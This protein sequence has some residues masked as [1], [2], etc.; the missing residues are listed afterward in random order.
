MLARA[1]PIEQLRL[2]GDDAPV[3]AIWLSERQSVFCLVDAVD[4]PWICQRPY[5]IGWKER[6]RWKLYAKRNIGTNRT[7]V[8][9]HREIQMLADPRD[10]NFMSWHHVDHINGQCLDNRRCNLRWLTPTENRLHVTPREQIPSLA[11]IVAQILA[12]RAHG[13]APIEAIPF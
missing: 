3:R 9:L 2:L 4:Y 7:T 1:D 10:E 13:Q 11:A 8:Y 12:E 5:N 6:A